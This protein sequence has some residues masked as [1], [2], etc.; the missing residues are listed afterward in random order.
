MLFLINYSNI[1]QRAHTKD[2][3]LWSFLTA[4]SGLRKFSA[5]IQ[6]GRS[7]GVP[8]R[9]SIWSWAMWSSGRSGSGGSKWFPQRSQCTAAQ[10][11]GKVYN[12]N[13]TIVTN[14]KKRLIYHFTLYQSINVARPQE[15]KL[16][17]NLAV[18]INLTITVSDQ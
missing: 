10:S 8:S 5:G 16:I 18:E 4:H 9:Q 6:C 15:R 12:N 1:C 11:T 2:S 3:R 17:L 14:K 7:Y 13:Y